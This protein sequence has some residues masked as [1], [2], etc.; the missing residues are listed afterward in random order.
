M[1]FK[2]IV[3]TM[4]IMPFLMVLWMINQMIKDVK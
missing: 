2:I 3:G 1:M 4:M